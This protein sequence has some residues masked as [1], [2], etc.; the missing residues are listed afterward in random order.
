PA[1]D[2]TLRVDM[3]GHM[4]ELLRKDDDEGATADPTSRH[5]GHNHNAS[6][7]LGDRDLIRE[8]RALLEARAPVG[9]GGGAAQGRERWGRCST[10]L[11]E[12]LRG[13]AVN[14]TVVWTLG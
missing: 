4:I 9:G 13:I 3:R 10:D 2:D 12:V 7:G 5:H 8:D 1:S 14:D 11:D 6:A